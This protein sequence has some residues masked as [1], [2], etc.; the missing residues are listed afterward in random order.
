MSKTGVAASTRARGRQSAPS[1]LSTSR[2]LSRL[3]MSPGQERARGRLEPRRPPGPGRPRTASRAPRPWSSL[4]SRTARKSH[5]TE[6]TRPA[7]A[8]AAYRGARSS[9]KGRVGDVARRVVAVLRGAPVVPAAGAGA[10][11]VATVTAI[12]ASR[13]PVVM[14]PAGVIDSVAERLRSEAVPALRGNSIDLGAE[15]DVDPPSLDRTGQKAGLPG[16]KTESGFC[17][18][19]YSAGPADEAGRGDRSGRTTGGGV[20]PVGPR[21]GR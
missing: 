15:G 9:H 6:G 5:S 11:V 7:P 10:P 14:V 19:V 18:C 4:P 12:P 21:A 2:P 3:T 17:F 8:R 20:P 1:P 16:S 13:S